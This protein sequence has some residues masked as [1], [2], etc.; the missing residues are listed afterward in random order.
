MNYRK[1]FGEA[2]SGWLWRTTPLSIGLLALAIVLLSLQIA[3]DYGPAVG[4]S[5]IIVG[6]VTLEPVALSLVASILSIASE[7]GET[8][9]SSR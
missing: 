1:Q 8:A 6:K 5:E 4:V 9:E 3:G 7:N 2:V